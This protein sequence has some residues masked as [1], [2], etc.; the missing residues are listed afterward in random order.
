MGIIMEQQ[1]PINELTCGSDNRTDYYP[2]RPTIEDYKP[3]G[4][5]EGQPIPEYL[6]NGG[7]Q[8]CI[9]KPSQAKI[10]IG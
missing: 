10:N 7:R 5:F 1:Y 8:K 6:T 2:P 9:R 3:E 4:I